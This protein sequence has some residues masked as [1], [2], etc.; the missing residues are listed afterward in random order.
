MATESL[1]LVMA[2]DGLTSR[3]GFPISNYWGAESNVDVELLYF[4]YLG[5]GE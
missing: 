2:D 5:S 4:L 3:S 1:M